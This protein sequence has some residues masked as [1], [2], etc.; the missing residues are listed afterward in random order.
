MAILQKYMDATSQQFA[1]DLQI[2]RIYVVFHESFRHMSSL[3]SALATVDLDHLKRC[4]LSVLNWS[5]TYIPPKSMRKRSKAPP[6]AHDLH[7]DDADDRTGSPRSKKSTTPPANMSDR[8][9][10]TA[11]PEFH[12]QRMISDAAKSIISL[13]PGSVAELLRDLGNILHDFKVTCDMNL[14]FGFH[15]AATQPDLFPDLIS[16]TATLFQRCFS[17]DRD[18]PPTGAV[19]EARHLVFTLAQEG[20]AGSDV[21]KALLA[22][23]CGQCLMSVSKEYSASGSEDDAA[24]KLLETSND[25]FEDSFE[26]AF[27]DAE[28]WAQTATDGSPVSTSGLR[29]KLLPFQP[30]LARMES[31]IKRWSVRGLEANFDKLETIIKNNAQITGLMLLMMCKVVYWRF[32]TMS[33]PAVCVAITSAPI[34]TM[35][36]RA[37]ADASDIAEGASSS[38]AVAVVDP[39]AEEATLAVAAFPSIHT[40]ALCGDDF[41]EGLHNVAS[42]T[43]SD[44]DS[45]QDIALGILTPLSSQVQHSVGKLGDAANQMFQGLGSPDSWIDEAS[46]NAT[47]INTM[48]NS[49]AALPI[50][51]MRSRSTEEGA[52]FAGKDCFDYEQNAFVNRLVSFAQAHHE[53]LGGSLKNFVCQCDLLGADNDPDKLFKDFMNF[54]TSVGDTVFEQKMSRF[55]EATFRCTGLAPS[56]PSSTLSLKPQLEI[57]NTLAQPGTILGNEVCLGLESL[58]SCVTS[59]TSGFKA[60]ER[61]RS[62]SKLGCSFSPRCVATARHCCWQSPHCV[63]FFGEGKALSGAACTPLMRSPPRSSGRA[64]TSLVSTTLC[65]RRRPRPTCCPSC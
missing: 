1:P 48:C 43:A 16:A 10:I 53:I 63:L 22:C 25:A 28:A 35:T 54:A 65:W 26:C 42:S 64:S 27:T 8:L 44:I 31:A 57:C 46:T 32:R 40:W 14:R 15:A 51:C 23:P 11:P 41:L 52:T 55:V 24:E 38:D 21:A 58:N 60:I 39:P 13:L 62:L 29:E 30:M 47:T 56:E 49:L 59:H 33:W 50:V 18:R 34:V 45:T 61:H 7:D 17:E 19:L 4:R 3:S 6:V 37:E 36:D 9:N 2:I 20:G 12:I 5:A